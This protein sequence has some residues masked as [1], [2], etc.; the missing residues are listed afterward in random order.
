MKA[1]RAVSAGLAGLGGRYHLWRDRR[2]TPYVVGIAGLLWTS[3]VPPRI[4][5]RMKTH[6][7]AFCLGVWVMGTV[8]V[9]IVAMQNFYTIDRLLDGP[10]HA[11]FAA[12]IEDNGREDVRNVLRYLSSE[13][14]RLFFQLWNVAQLAIGA[15]VLWLLWNLRSPVAARL[16]WTV[17][18][19]LAV[20]VVLTVGITPQILEIGRSI[21]F[22]PRDPPPAAVA[23]F[24]VLHAAYTLLELAKCG[25]AIMAALWLFRPGRT[26][27]V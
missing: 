6:A 25:A 7:A 16:R 3:V 10:S 8:C 22:V 20:V 12:F 19:M 2:W 21:D 26:E 4:V 13:L 5:R 1:I 15:A 9:S 17:I 24:G 23:T 27:T 18:G 14:N 11:T